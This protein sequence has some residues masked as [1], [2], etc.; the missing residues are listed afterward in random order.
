M[1]Y[2]NMKPFKLYFVK[3]GEILNQEPYEFM[4]CV[5]LKHI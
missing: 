4:F 5:L 1:F 3:E 2:D